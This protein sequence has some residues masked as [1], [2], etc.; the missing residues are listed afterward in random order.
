MA[1]VATKPTAYI[2]T[3]IPSYLTAWP[4]HA[5]L[6]AEYQRLTKQWWATSGQRYDRLIS[7]TVI[8]EASQG[9]ASAVNDRMAE[10]RKLE[11]LPFSAEALELAKEYVS[12]LQLPPKAQN[13]A[14]HLAYAV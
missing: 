5:P 3:T 11:V 6:I 12:L 8:D 1:E 2:E 9:D 14:S 10:L 13:D 4:S 7:Q